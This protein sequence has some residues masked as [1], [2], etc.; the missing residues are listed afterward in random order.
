MRSVTIELPERLGDELEALVNAGWFRDETEL[1]RL[2]LVEFLHRHSP[3]L[4]Q[5]FQRD[6][7]DWALRQ[8]DAAG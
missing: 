3:D 6:D 4:I 5:Q 7:I 8:K 2:A 1:V